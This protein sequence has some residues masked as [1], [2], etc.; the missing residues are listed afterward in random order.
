MSISV[1]EAYIEVNGVN[2]FRGNASAISLGDYGRKKAPVFGVNFL[3]V[4]N[5]AGL[6]DVPV[7]AKVEVEFE[8]EALRKVLGKGNVVF[9][10]NHQAGVEFSAEAQNNV[11]LHL[12]QLAISLKQVEANVLDTEDEEDFQRL[13]PKARVVYQVWIVMEAEQAKAIKLATNLRAT[14]IQGGV[15]ISGELGGEISSKKFVRL[16]AGSTFAYLLAKRKPN[17]FFTTDQQ[18]SS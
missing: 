15:V 5:N 7:E 17:S 13:G 14:A 2:Y 16:S 4:Y 12:V 18:G 11:K 10:Q 1:G 3:E 9:T 6:A 8:Q